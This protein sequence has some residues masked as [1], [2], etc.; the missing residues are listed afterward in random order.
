MYEQMIKPNIPIKPKKRNRAIPVLAVLLGASISFSSLQSIGLIALGSGLLRNVIQERT[1]D[2]NAADDYDSPD[3]SVDNTE[4]MKNEDM[5]DG[6]NDDNNT[7]QSVYD[8]SFSVSAQKTD[9]NDPN[10]K[11]LSTTEIVDKVSPATV[12]VFI[13]GE[14]NGENQKI[15]AGSGFIISESG[16]MI[17]NAHVVSPVVSYPSCWIEVMIPGFD[18]SIKAKIIGFDEQTDIA[19]LKLEEDNQYNCVTLGDSNVLKSGEPVVVI[20]NAL[21]SFDGTVTAGVVSGLN[22]NISNNGYS[23]TLIQTDASI[24][25]GN[26]GGP[27]IN[28]FGEVVGITNSK[29][30]TAEGLGFAIPISDVKDEIDSIIQNGYVANR[31]YLGLSTLKVD[32]G[33]YYGIEPG[34][35]VAEVTEGGPA[36]KAGLE[37][38]D[39]I[40]SIDGSDISESKEILRIRNSHAV[41]D[42]LD[43]TVIRNGKEKTLSIT[44][45]DGVN[46]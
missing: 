38:G 5:N 8:S 14:I 45:G 1:T 18:N 21:G 20:G 40:I 11:T 6:K 36:D 25:S 19:V 9:I 17:T 42:V 27:L 7:A 22:R 37:V 10:R 32:D 24:N 13:M 16:Y 43:I 41:G 46:N 26:S 15:A 35:Y 4:N 23:M 44:I 29:I 31:P 12:S 39:R 33:S 34:L 28:S 3:V 30:A 2:G